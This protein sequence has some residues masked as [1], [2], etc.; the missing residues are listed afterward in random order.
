M[1]DKEDVKEKEATEELE[2]EEESSAAE[3]EASD[4]DPEELEEDDE[5]E[6]DEPEAAPGKKSNDDDLSQYSHSVRRR[7]KKMAAK[8]RALEKRELDALEYARSVKLEL[9]QLK[10][11]EMQLSRNLE[12][13]A[14]VRLKTQEQ[15]LKDQYKFAVDSGDVDKQIEAQSTLAQ[16]A[17]EKERLRNFRVYREEQE[18]VSVQRDAVDAR[19]QAAPPPPKP[20]KKAQDWANRNQWFG[21]DRAMTFTAYEVHNDLMAEGYDGKDDDYYS[22]LDARLRR[23][24]PS[25]FKEI[26]QQRKPASTVASGRPTQ[27]KKASSDPELSD[28]Q[29]NIARRLGVSYDDYKRQLKLARERA[30]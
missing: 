30:E 5:D 4:V 29:K 22:E 19:P 23:E 11:R 18:R 9:D 8:N 6:G 27:G 3:A 20:D 12:T 26:V 7:M 16:L 13:E 24:F 1:L 14:E 15:L 10:K 25:K 21:K 2:T 28:S 17:V